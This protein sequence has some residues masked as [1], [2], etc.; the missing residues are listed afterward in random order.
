MQQSFKEDLKTNES[1]RLWHDVTLVLND[2]RQQMQYFGPPIPRTLRKN[3]T[4]EVF[5]F[6]FGTVP[7]VLHN[8]SD[9]FIMYCGLASQTSITTVFFGTSSEK[10]NPNADYDH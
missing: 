1:L 7:T 9:F 10:N 6:F 2:Y 5:F 4:E 8:A 3:N